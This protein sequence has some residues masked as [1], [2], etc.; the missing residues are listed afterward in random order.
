MSQQFECEVVMSLETGLHAR[1]AGVLVKTAS[2]FKS[3]I[4]LHKN[5]LKK[6][7]KSVMSLLSLG[8]QKGDT[9][10]IIAI[11]QY[12]TLAGSDVQ[13]LFLNHFQA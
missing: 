7:A 6:N 10:K 4:E 1:P 12:A 3:T 5:G 2:Q 9:S 8:A 13:E 11:G